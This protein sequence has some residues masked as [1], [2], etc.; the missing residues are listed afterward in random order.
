MR[1]VQERR[2]AGCPAGRDV[3]GDAVFGDA[4]AKRESQQPPQHTGTWSSC[5]AACI[6]AATRAWSLIV[7]S[8][9]FCECGIQR[10][11]L[12]ASSMTT[13]SQR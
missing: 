7:T 13:K 9:W 4:I 10:A 1:A 11:L 2:L 8:F 3:V 12:R 6:A 5:A